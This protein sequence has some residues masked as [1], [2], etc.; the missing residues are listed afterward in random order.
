MHRC[1]A[2]DADL[3]LDTW[4]WRFLDLAEA[5]TVHRKLA[6]Y[7]GARWLDWPATLRRLQAAATGDGQQ[8]CAALP[9]CPPTGEHALPTRRQATLFPLHASHRHHGGA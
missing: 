3:V 5:E 6:G 4:P 8:R 2:S 9:P 1:N 7:R